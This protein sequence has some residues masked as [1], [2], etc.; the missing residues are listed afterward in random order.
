MKKIIKGVTLQLFEEDDYR[1]IRSSQ[2]KETGLPKRFIQ[3]YSIQFSD[4]YS[5]PRNFHRM[6]IGWYLNHSAEPNVFCDDDYNFFA[7]R[8]IKRNE[9]LC[10]DYDEL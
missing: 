7:L 10:V 2:I 1:F 9:E 5:S 3:K 6:S 8:N 4:G